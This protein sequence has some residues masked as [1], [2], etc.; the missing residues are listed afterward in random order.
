MPLDL[1]AKGSCLIG[2]NVSTNAGG[3]RLLRYGN[4]HGSLLGLEAVSFF[5]IFLFLTFLRG[6]IVF[7]L[8]IFMLLVI[9]DLLSLVLNGLYEL[10]ILANVFPKIY[11]FF[12]LRFWILS[13]FEAFYFYFD[14]L[15][16][17]FY[18]LFDYYYMVHGQEKICNFNELQSNS[19]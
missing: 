3:I 2:G 19:R 8:N 17:P 6:N 13:S 1:G 7:E 9:R 15:F 16:D 10:L 14:L 12:F 5:F 4:L 18:R 11:G